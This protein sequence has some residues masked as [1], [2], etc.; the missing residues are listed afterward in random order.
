MVLHFHTF[1]ALETSKIGSWGDRVQIASDL[2]LPVLEDTWEFTHWCFRTLQSKRVTAV[3]NSSTLHG[4]TCEKGGGLPSFWPFP[5]L[6]KKV[7]PLAKGYSPERCQ[8][9]HVISELFQAVPEW[10][11]RHKMYTKCG[12]LWA[13]GWHAL[14]VVRDDRLYSRRWTIWT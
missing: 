6:E 4:K 8:R 13:E 9:D 12:W 5:L 3:D 10:R 2:F 1:S 11:Q 7:I 14:T